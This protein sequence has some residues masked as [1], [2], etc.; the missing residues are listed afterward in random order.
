MKHR[1]DPM[2]MFR[3]FSKVT[4]FTEAELLRL[5]QMRNDYGDAKVEVRNK[6]GDWNNVEVPA[7]VADLKAQG[8]AH[9]C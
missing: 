3:A 5:E 8:Y 4:P 1:K 2:A 7:T 9:E 6:D